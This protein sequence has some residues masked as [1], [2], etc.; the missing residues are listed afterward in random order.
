[1]SLTFRIFGIEVAS[2]VLD[3]PDEQTPTPLE[4]N[5]DKG[6]KVISRWWVNRGMK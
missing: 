2:I 4:R 5:M 6:I 3:L 1:M